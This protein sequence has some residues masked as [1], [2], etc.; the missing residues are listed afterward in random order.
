[1]EVITILQKKK[2]KRIRKDKEKDRAAVDLDKQW[3]ERTPLKCFRCGS[4]DHLISK[5]QKPHKDNKK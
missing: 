1:M 4:V 2:I 5:F 3:T